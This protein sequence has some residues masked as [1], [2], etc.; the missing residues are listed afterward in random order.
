MYITFVIPCTKKPLV[1]LVLKS[2]I[3]H[4]ET[5]DSLSYAGLPKADTFRDQVITFI[6]I[7]TGFI[8][9]SLG[10]GKLSSFPASHFHLKA[11][12]LLL[13]INTLDCFP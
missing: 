12:I 10:T 8:I 9:N 11:G 7:I 3:R 1:C 6:N 5:I 4:L 13:A 2:S